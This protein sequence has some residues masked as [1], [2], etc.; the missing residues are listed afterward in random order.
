M[1]IVIKPCIGNGSRG[2]RILDKNADRFD[3][4]FNH[5][6]NSIFST[7]NEVLST[8]GDKKIPKIFLIKF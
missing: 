5:K 8:M 7:L 4:L 1:P 3:M 6:P 2:I